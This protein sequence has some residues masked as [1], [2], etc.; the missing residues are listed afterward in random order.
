MDSVCRSP[1]LPEADALLR[2]VHWTSHASRQLRRRLTDVAGCF[3]L[4]DTEL[5]VLWV[6]TGGGYAQIDL[7]GEI[8]VSPA[9]TSGMVERLHSRGLI[10]MRR[11]AA[12][13]RRQVCETTA[14]GLEVLD[15]AAVE[16]KVLSR[17]IGVDLDAQERQLAEALCQRLTAV[18]KE[19][20]QQDKQRTS[21][22]A[23]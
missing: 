14:A 10:A 5:L 11:Q 17:S 22:E 4:S 13:R 2:L 7:A 12:D 1:D 19:S 8:G 20:Q 15:R 3:D 18:L 6:C 23:A 16:L 21:K 9:Q